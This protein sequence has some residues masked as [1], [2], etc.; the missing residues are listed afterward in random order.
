MTT[1]EVNQRMTDASARL[2]KIEDRFKAGK[3]TEERYHEMRQRILDQTPDF[4]VFEPNAFFATAIGQQKLIKAVL[5]D[6]VKR[7]VLSN[8][9]FA[10]RVPKGQT[11]N[12][13]P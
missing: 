13:G 5:A 7:Q 1:A 8:T 10:R 12:L 4:E 9:N 6:D 11:P 2:E 3:M